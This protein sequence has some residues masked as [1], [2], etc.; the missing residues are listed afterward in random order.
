MSEQQIRHV[1]MTIELWENLNVETTLGIPASLGRDGLPGCGYL[2]VFET[3]EEAERE[4][5]GRQIVTVQ[6]TPEAAS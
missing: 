5:P 4:Y 1:V 2:P 6:A 3:S